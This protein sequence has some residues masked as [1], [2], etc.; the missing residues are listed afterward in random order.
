MGEKGLTGYNAKSLTM[1]YKRI[2]CLESVT[3]P[4]SPTPNFY[5][6]KRSMCNVAAT[7]EEIAIPNPFLRFSC[8]KHVVVRL[9]H[10]SSLLH[11]LL[12]VF[13]GG[14]IFF[15]WGWGGLLVFALL[16]VLRFYILLHLFSF[17]RRHA[18]FAAWR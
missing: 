13:L 12:L 16:F 18:I 14:F 10:S 1:D 17:F 11:C 2:K 3:L 8:A 9:S 4:K 15:F 5:I 6:S 7:E